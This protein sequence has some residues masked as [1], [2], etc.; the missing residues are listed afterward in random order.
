[1]KSTKVMLLSTTLVPCIL[2]CCSPLHTYYVAHHFSRFVLLLTMLLCLP[3]HQQPQR[4]K[5]LLFWTKGAASFLIPVFLA[6]VTQ[7]TML[8]SWSKLYKVFARCSALVIT[9]EENICCEELCA[10]MTAA[11]DRETLMVRRWERTCHYGKN[12]NK[13]VFSTSGRIVRSSLPL[14]R[15][16]SY[17]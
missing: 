17:W 10:K 3:N 6:Q 4:T 15:N 16:L 1:M 11:I 5:D 2:P 14:W 7:K 8:S 9:A 13:D 12:R